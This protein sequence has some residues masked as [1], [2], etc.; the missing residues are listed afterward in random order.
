MPLLDIWP[1]SY[2]VEKA[3]NQINPIRGGTRPGISKESA[4]Q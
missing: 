4:S 3:P 1:L 2:D